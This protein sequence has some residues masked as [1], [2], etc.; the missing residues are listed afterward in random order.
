MKMKWRMEGAV[1]QEGTLCFSFSLSSL[2]SDCS[3]HQ[4]LSR[5][6]LTPS[7]HNTQRWQPPSLFHLLLPPVLLPPSPTSAEETH[8]LRTRGEYAWV[9]W[10]PSTLSEVPHVFLFLFIFLVL[11]L[12][13]VQWNQN[14]SRQ[15]VWVGECFSFM[16]KPL[17]WAPTLS[18]PSQLQ[19]VTSQRPC[20]LAEKYK[21]IFLVHFWKIKVY[22]E[23]FRITQS[24]AEEHHP[25]KISWW[26]TVN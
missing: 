21:G 6:Q 18:A 20:S 8:D 1:F 13:N 3:W 14:I 11:H 10:Q 12:H 4:P 2:F 25:V 24:F 7:Q 15:M 23:K 17:L 9:E 19:L 26:P 16:P 22:E 5:P